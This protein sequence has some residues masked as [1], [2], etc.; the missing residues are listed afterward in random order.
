V[1]VISTFF[2]FDFFS[3]LIIFAIKSWYNKEVIELSYLGKCQRSQVWNSHSPCHL[4]E[5]EAEPERPQKGLVQMGGWRGGEHP[6]FFTGVREIDTWGPTVKGTG[7]VCD[8]KTSEFFVSC[9]KNPWQD[10]WV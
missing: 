8:Q 9:G 6:L 4:P 2:S 10:T 5:E 1:G 7:A 3:F